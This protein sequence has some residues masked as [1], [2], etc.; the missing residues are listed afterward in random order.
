MKI[1]AE[2]TPNRE[3]V[4]HF[5]F[6]ENTQQN[7]HNVWV[8]DI[9]V[10][11]TRS[12]LDGICVYKKTYDPDIAEDQTTYSDVTEFITDFS[13]SEHDINLYDTLMHNNNTDGCHSTDMFNDIMIVSVTF[14]YDAQ[15]WASFSC[16]KDTPATKTV[17]LYYPCTIYSRA[18]KAMSGCSC[19]D[20]CEDNLPYGFMYELLKKK[21]V[22]SCIGSGDY[23]M[24]CRYYM[25]FFRNDGCNCIDK[26]CGCGNGSES[27]GLTAQSS[28]STSKN[29]GC[30]G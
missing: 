27:Y 18:M 23:D 30:H 20:M 14:G 15:Y 16:C 19:K 25:K 28:G 12:Y 9:E 24:A 10:F 13:I 3:L 8:G 6:P 29:C 2:I 7:P 21:A 26:G 4:V 11:N 22:D 5:D 1:N 17:A